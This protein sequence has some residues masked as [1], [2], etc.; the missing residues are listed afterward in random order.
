MLLGMFLMSSLFFPH[1]FKGSQDQT[2]CV[3]IVDDSF[4]FLFHY[5]VPCHRLVEVARAC[6]R[7]VSLMIPENKKIKTNQQEGSS[8]FAIKNRQLSPLAGT[9]PTSS[10]QQSRSRRRRWLRRGQNRLRRARKTAFHDRGNN[11]TGLWR[12]PYVHTT[13]VDRGDWIYL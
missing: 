13:Q 2:T 9:N 6:L 11:R 1:F 3:T 5:S 8:R 12:I 7:Y 10:P 4:C